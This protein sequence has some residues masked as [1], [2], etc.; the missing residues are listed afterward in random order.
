MNH[1]S[2]SW[3]VEKSVLNDYVTDVKI[4]YPIKDKN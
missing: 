2:D 1:F 4:D 3:D